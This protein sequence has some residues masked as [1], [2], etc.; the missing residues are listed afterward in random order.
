MT[1]RLFLFLMATALFFACSNASQNS[2][3][4]EK[5]DDMAQFANDEEFKDAHEKPVKVEG[6]RQGKEIKFATPDG[7][8]VVL[9]VGFLNITLPVLLPLRIS[10]ELSL[11]LEIL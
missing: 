6:E 4:T 10:P 11:N 5:S 2:K 3:E 7:N 9:P 8:E 1:F